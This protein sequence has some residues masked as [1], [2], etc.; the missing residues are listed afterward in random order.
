MIKTYLQEARELGL[1]RLTNT[2]VIKIN[3]KDKNKIS[4]KIEKNKQINFLYAK[5]VVLSSGTGFHSSILKNL[6]YLRIK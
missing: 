5:K 3:N 1:K 2:K 6:R 4:I